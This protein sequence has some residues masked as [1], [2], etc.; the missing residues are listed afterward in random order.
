MDTEDDAILFEVDAPGVHTTNVRTAAFL[1]AAAAYFALLEATA[2]SAGRELRIYGVAVVEKCAAVIAKTSSPDDAL[3]AAQ[4]AQ[5]ILGR[6][7]PPHGYG[8][9]VSRLRGAMFVLDGHRARARVGREIMDLP[10]HHEGRSRAPFGT[11]SLRATLLRVGGSEPRARFKA[12][13]EE[14]FTVELATEAVAQALAPHF[15]GSLT[16]LP[17][18]RGARSVISTRGNCRS[19]SPSK[20]SMQKMLPRSC[21][22]G[23]VQ[24]RSIGT[25]L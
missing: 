15:T 23:S 8:A 21:D 20:T 22:H 6:D 13:G 16:S 24:T 7:E 11:I 25:S 12:I 19:S 5:A 2:K 18:C 14:D 17:R 9:V 10:V 4:D 1:E 3:A